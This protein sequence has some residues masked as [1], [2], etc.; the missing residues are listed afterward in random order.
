LKTRAHY[1]SLFTLSPTDFEGWAYG[2][3][4]AG[5]ATNPKYPQIIIKLIKDYNLQDYTLIAL[6]KIKDP[7]EPAWVAAPKTNTV[8]DAK[9]QF[10][11]GATPSIKYNYPSGVF[12]INDTKVI[13]VEAGTSFLKIAEEHDVLLSRL[14]EFNDLKPEEVAS[15]DG[16]IFLQRKRKTGATDFHIVAPGETISQIAQHKGIRKESLLEFNHLQN[17]ME[18]REGEK[19]Y[20]KTKAPVMPR[21]VVMEK[22]VDEIPAPKIT[23]N[24]EKAIGT[25]I[26]TVQPKETVYA[27]AKKYEVEIE[28][29]LSG[30]IFKGTI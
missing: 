28:D 25:I 29:V 7:N 10:A 16:L 5:Y 4:K 17:G 6:N 2:L 9:P 12:S 1:N 19:L 14:F 18:P 3:K 8:V 22:P 13:F 15:Q 11:V 27:I 23:M 20:L 24:D 21:L 30:I 26:H